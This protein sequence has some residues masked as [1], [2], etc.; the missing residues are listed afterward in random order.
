MGF[1]KLLLGGAAGACLVVAAAPAISSAAASPASHP[2]VISDDAL[3]AEFTVGAGAKV[4][5]TT[6]TV[7]HWYGHTTDPQN[8]VTYGYNMVGADPNNC[9]GSACDV[10]VPVDITP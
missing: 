3:K 5:P 8:G 10:S 7:A 2:Q 9:S 4:L 6:R 1:G